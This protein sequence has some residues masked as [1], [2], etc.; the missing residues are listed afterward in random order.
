LEDFQG[1]YISRRRITFVGSDVIMEVLKVV[2]PVWFRSCMDMFVGYE[3]KDSFL[4]ETEEG[5][6]TGRGDSRLGELEMMS[7]KH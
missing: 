7:V 5:C 1:R 3:R 4:Y 6:S 2:V